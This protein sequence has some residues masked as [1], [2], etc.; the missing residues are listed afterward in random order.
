MK[1]GVVS[2]FFV[3]TFL[4]AP[5]VLFAQQG[6]AQPPETPPA[7]A[8]GVPPSTG[9]EAHHP[10]EE[11]PDQQEMRGMMDMHEKMMARMKDMNMQLD[12]KVQAMQSATA[13]DQ[14]L[15]AMEAVI[16]ELISQ[17]KE[18]MGKMMGMH[19]RMC[20]MMSGM[21]GEGMMG[22]QEGGMMRLKGKGKNIFIIIQE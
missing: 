13:P 9:H 15:E 19:G 17:R 21:K 2:I 18:M 22:M 4:L 7:A 5:C 3:L 11:A 12:Q 14:K 10:T 20:K 1:T 8:P 6:S 16:T